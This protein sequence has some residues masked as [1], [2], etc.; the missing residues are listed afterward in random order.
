LDTYTSPFATTFQQTIECLTGHGMQDTLY[1]AAAIRWGEDPNGSGGGNAVTPIDGCRAQLQDLLAQ[2][3]D[4]QRSG[5]CTLDDA[6]TLRKCY[7]DLMDELLQQRSSDGAE[8]L[9]LA[10]P[11][12]KCLNYL[13]VLAD[14]FEGRSSALSY[15]AELARRIDAAR[16]FHF[17]AS[18]IWAEISNDFEER[19]DGWRKWLEPLTAEELALSTEALSECRRAADFWCGRDSLSS[20][21]IKDLF[22]PWVLDG[23][24]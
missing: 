6:E 23:R 1:E 19:R 4:K 3:E 14:R 15:R 13:S 10:P 7:H 11:E 20:S 5:S 16:P 9:Q 18:S 24:G 12:V 8:E 2:V 17:G 22:I 21:D